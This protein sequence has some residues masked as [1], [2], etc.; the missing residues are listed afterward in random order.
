VLIDEGSPF[1][2]FAI[3]AAIPTGKSSGSLF[4][5]DSAVVDKP[6]PNGQSRDHRVA[7]C[8]RWRLENIIGR[9]LREK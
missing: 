5:T 1:R 2:V 3:I 9:I 7:D 4:L 6:R 8:K